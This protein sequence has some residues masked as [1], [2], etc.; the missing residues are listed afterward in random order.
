MNRLRITSNDIR[1]LQ[2]NGVFVFDSNVYGQH[3]S[4]TTRTAY[5]KFG[6]KWEQGIGFY[7]QSYAI[8]TMHGDLNYIG[9]Y[10]M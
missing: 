1:S 9:L 7:R 5:E 4:G 6:A 3:G 10:L 8:P 2:P